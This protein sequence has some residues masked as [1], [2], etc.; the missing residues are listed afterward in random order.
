ML[1]AHDRRPG[2]GGAGAR[3]VE[4]GQ[5]TAPAP[6]VPSLRGKVARAAILIQPQFAR[7]PLHLILQ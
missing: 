5:E 7:A 2:L 3:T 1:G 4:P 6:G